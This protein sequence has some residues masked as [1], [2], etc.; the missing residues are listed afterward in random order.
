MLRYLDGAVPVR[1][2]RVSLVAGEYTYKN[3]L[4]IL[5]IQRT[6]NYARLLGRARFGRFYHRPAHRFAL[7]DFPTARHTSPA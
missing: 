3:R 5:A 7:E 6:P 1:F 2:G 4:G